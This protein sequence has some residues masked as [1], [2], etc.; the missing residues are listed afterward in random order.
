MRESFEGQATD[1]QDTRGAHGVTLAAP[2][3]EGPMLQAPQKQRELEMSPGEREL[4]VRAVHLVQNKAGLSDDEARKVATDV[5]LTART[6]P[7]LSEKPEYMDVR[8]GHVML[9]QKID[10]EPI[11]SGYVNIEQSKTQSEQQAAAKID[12]HDRVLQERQA[13]DAEREAKPLAQAVEDRVT[14]S[15]TFSR[16]L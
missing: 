6:T 3:R 11:F 8:N 7:G 10:R 9:A 16:S 2:E 15:F 4:Y 1:A 5:V 14:N 12:Q 13:R